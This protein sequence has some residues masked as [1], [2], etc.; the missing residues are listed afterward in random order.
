MKSIEIVIG[1]TNFHAS[2]NGQILIW[3]ASN[4]CCRLV[5]KELYILYFCVF[6]IFLHEAFHLPAMG[7]L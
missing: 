3:R 1:L 4:V 5:Q 2:E 6:N 7:S